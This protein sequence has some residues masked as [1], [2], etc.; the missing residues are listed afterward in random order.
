MGVIDLLHQSDTESALQL[1]LVTA[2]SQLLRSKKWSEMRVA[3][4]QFRRRLADP[5]FA[6]ARESL[7]RWVQSTLQDEFGDTSMTAG[8]NFEE[9]ATMLFDRRFNTV[10]ELW[11]YEEKELIRK[12]KAEITEKFGIPTDQ[13]T[14]TVLEAEIKRARYGG[15]RDALYAGRDKGYADGLK[16]GRIEG[17]AEGHADGLAE[18]RDEGREEGREEDRKA[19]IEVL[20]GLLAKS[21]AVLPVEANKKIAVADAGR[22]SEW[23]TRLV[24]G[25]DPNG[26]FS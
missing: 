14:Q 15:M 18:G 16:H 13:D 10:E 26:L 24:A 5:D 23:V 12:Q 11:D 2:I 21:D 7:M 6:R 22:L 1:N 9:G 20:Y 8:A 4:L 19:W 17:R 3:L 25:A